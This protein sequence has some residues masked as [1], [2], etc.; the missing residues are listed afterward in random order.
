ME[1]D[2]VSATQKDLKYYLENPDDMPTDPKEIE[3]LANEHMQAA[4][5]LG[6]E[7]LSIDN[8]VQKDE[9][10]PEVKAEAAEP[11]DKVKETETPKAEEAKEAPKEEPKPQAAEVKPEGV[12]AKDGKN[13][14]PYAVLESA[15]ERAAAA[16]QLAAEQLKELE[17]LRA[18]KP[19]EREEPKSEMLSDE[20]LTALEA[21]SPTLAK[22]LRAQQATIQNLTGTV[23]Q[24][25]GREEQRTSTEKA[26]VKSEIQTAIDAV[27]KLAAWQAAED[28]TAFNIASLHDKTLRAIP[29]YKDVSFED[30]FKKVVELTEA[31]LAEQQEET[32]A[33]GKPEVK[34]PTATEVRAAAEAKLAAAKSKGVPKSLSDI[35]GGAP[36]AVDERERIEQMSVFELG[37]KFMGMSPEQ[38]EAYLSGL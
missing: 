18:Q 32:P 35:P 27:P 19:K 1:R 21:E 38:R 28:K 15:R 4:M 24:I 25:K 13:V 36:P 34:A 29:K 30:R 3:R 8:L 11:D 37:N 23:E 12:L 17:T 26:E 14:I 22:L 20:E 10:K 2:T 5:E 7:Q 31:T 16:E 6:A 9:P 33:A